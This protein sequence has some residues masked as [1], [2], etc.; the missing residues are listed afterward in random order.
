MK[1][2]PLA[3]VSF[4]LTTILV[5]SM[6][7]A[8]ESVATFIGVAIVKDGDGI[9][10]G[11]VEVRLQGIAAPEDNGHKRDPGGPAS[12]ANLRALVE[13]KMLRCELDGSTARISL[14]TG[15]APRRR[16]RFPVP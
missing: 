5:V 4:A 11:K 16:L 8:F 12:S 2:W 3:S 15:R 10:F 13:G 14:S 7:N 9:L 1:K 6:G